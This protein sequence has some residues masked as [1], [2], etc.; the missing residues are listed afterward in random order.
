[1][2]VGK[3]VE[4]GPPQ[5]LFKSPKHPYTAALISSLPKPDPAQRATREPLEGEIANPANPPQGC[6]FHP[7][8]P[9]AVEICKTVAPELKELS[10]GR[11][12]SCHR[13]EEL[14]LEGIPSI[15]EN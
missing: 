12:V 4:T 14:S 9:F 3:I 15:N 1:M 8:C 2:Y 5:E 6:Y 10:S 13:A 7:R 11:H